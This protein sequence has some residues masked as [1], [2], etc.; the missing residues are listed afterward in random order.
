MDITLPIIRSYYDV[1]RHLRSNKLSYDSLLWYIKNVMYDCDTTLS[2]LDKEKIIEIF[3]ELSLKKD[4]ENQMKRD[5]AN[6]KR[7][8]KE[9]KIYE[10]NI[11]AERLKRRADRFI[12]K[13]AARYRKVYLTFK[14]EFPSMEINHSRSDM[15]YIEKTQELLK[16]KNELMSEKSER[17]T[18]SSEDM[19][20]RKNERQ[21]HQLLI[22]KWLPGETDRLSKIDTEISSIS[23]RIL[24]LS[25]ELAYCKFEKLSLV[26]EKKDIEM[27]LNS[28]AT[29]DF[30]YEAEKNSNR[31]AFLSTELVT[32]TSSVKTED[33]VTAGAGAGSSASCFYNF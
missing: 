6:K 8:A 30:V 33:K 24:D 29:Y 23:I 22:N 11:K 10:D 13:S 19:L 2:E 18:M 5:K 15:N 20:S 17:T 4:A 3:T 9:K 27:F 12:K 16:I 32:T 31:F 25:R 1:I 14:N 28:R 26:K 7:I 21:I